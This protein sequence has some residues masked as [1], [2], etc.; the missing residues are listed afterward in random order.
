MV[1]CKEGSISSSKGA[2]DPQPLATGEKLEEDKDVYV[3][4]SSPG[5]SPPEVVPD[6]LL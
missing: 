5:L 4:L 2:G 3:V 6:I 1:V